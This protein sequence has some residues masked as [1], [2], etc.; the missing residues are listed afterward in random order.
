MANVEA[1]STRI[2]DGIAVI[3]LGSPKRIFFDAEMSDALL[4]KLS[5]FT[6]DDSVRVVVVTG[7]AP[8]YFVR[9]F[10][11]AELIQTGERLQSSGRKWAEDT[12]YK[13]GSFASS[14]RLAEQM[15]KP[16]IAAISGSAMGGAFEFALACDI[17]VAQLG[18]FQI[19]LPEI[20]LGILPGGG[21]TQRLPRVIGT[22]AALMH[23]L[24]GTTLSPLEAEQKGLIHEAVAGKALDR[25]MEIARQL[26]TYTPASVRY[27]KRL[28]RGALEAPL[29]KGLELERNLFM[30][31]CG[32]QEAI[33]RMNTYENMRI[34]DPSETLKI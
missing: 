25:A 24:M 13:A 17:R 15:P 14:M 9:H 11:V 26:A 5:A 1:L 4:E 10:S 2:E 21:G 33:E 34:T 30:D 31:L 28:V 32:S 20:K 27:I 22:S 6:D 8:G 16:V 23:I 29:S 3:V 7:G 18:N 12:P 19:G